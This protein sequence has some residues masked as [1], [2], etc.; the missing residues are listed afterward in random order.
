M[1]DAANYNGHSYLRTF[2][3]TN[4]EA[5]ACI[6]SLPILL[7]KE[8]GYFPFGATALD[9]YLYLAKRS[10]FQVFSL[11]NPV[12]PQLVGSCNLSSTFGWEYDLAAAGHYVYVA[13]G[14]SVRIVDISN[15]ANPSQVNS[16]GGYWVSSVAAAENMVIMD[17]RTRISIYDVNDPLNPALVGY[18][19]TAERITDMEIQGQYLFTISL[20]GQFNVF[21][22]DALAGMESTGAFTPH[23]FALY[24]CYPNPFNSTLVI[25]FTLP[26]QSK[27]TIT[28]YNILGQQVYQ[29]ESTHLSPGMHR[30]MWD[31]NDMASGIYIIQMSANGKEYRQKALLLK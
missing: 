17:D 7:L 5:P 1:F 11:A 21:Q 26:V 3:L 29:F 27:A 20:S 28:I 4:P 10:D 18:Y 30:A 14:Q 6:D 8:N 16:I 9:G 19:S 15:S 31:A 24:P 22:V 12:A 25:P 23:E 2:N 13:N